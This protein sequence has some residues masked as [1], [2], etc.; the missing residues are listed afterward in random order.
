[1]A[2]APEPRAVC[3]GAKST[4]DRRG[5]IGTQLDDC[6]Q[7]A[8]REGW[9]V[10][11]EHSDEGFSAY[12]GNRGPGLAR[13]REE[14]AANAPCRLVVQHS[15]RLARGAGDA[16]GAAEH[17]A[18]IVFWARRHD[19]QLR[20]VQDDFAFSH[21]LLAFAMGE[22]NFEDS[23][24]KSQATRAG[25]ERRKAA[26]KPVGAVLDGYR[27]E[28]SVEGDKAVTTR[29]VDPGRAQII[30]RIMD[31][32]ECGHTP[33]AV[34]RQLNR[35]GLRTRRG[36]TWNR[37]PVRKIAQN[38][39]YTGSTGYPPLVSAER[40]ARILAQL[41]RQDPVAVHARAGGRPT[42]R[43]YLLAGIARCAR[44]QAP[45][46]TR[47]H[48]RQR[49]YVCKAVRHGLGTCD[50][51][52]IPAEQV[53]R[54]VLDHLTGFVGNARE[55]LSAQ[56]QR[57]D[58]ERD[59]F[60]E[61]LEAQRAELRRLRLRAER[62]HEK[63]GD[64]L[65]AGDDSALYALKAAERMQDDADGLRDA[66]EAGE[67]QLAEWQA[68][69]IDAAL[70]LYSRLRDAIAGAI[71][72]TTSVADANRALKTVIATAALML[73]D[74][75]R[76]YGVFGLRDRRVAALRDDG[77]MAFVSKGDDGRVLLRDV[78]RTS[79]DKPPDR[80]S[81]SRRPERSRRGQVEPSARVQPAP[82][83]E[84]YGRTA[85]PTTSAERTR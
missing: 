63:Y 83:A 36:K 48:L 85:G 40:H 10:V 69:E 35:D 12:H 50:R 21:P 46:Y 2:S 47:T 42:K 31:G 26:G 5:S 19:V 24:R 16:P 39:A 77:C 84:G 17:L 27:V 58:D 3:Y 4:E 61:T 9:Q 76:I 30:G 57:A 71:A 59:R 34:A 6:R 25:L 8:E 60:A 22:R 56:A 43:P 75:G 37:E 11:A 73:G 33:G 49:S 14:A 23:R 28:A 15:D 7:L 32:I 51:R 62:A 1:M 20:S 29:V 55:W 18:E 64:L 79:L 38:P 53:E 70:D 65:D 78:E 54:A 74:D 44:C 41:Q 72:D 68:P 45:L 80:A 13:A 82:G 81:A 52:P 66:I 67:Q